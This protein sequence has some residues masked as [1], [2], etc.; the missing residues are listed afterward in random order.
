MRT[1]G[2][3]LGGKGDPG[4]PSGPWGAR[5]HLQPCR[6]QQR[7]C[8][9]S[10]GPWALSGGCGGGWCCNPRLHR[11]VGGGREPPHPGTKAH[12]HGTPGHCGVYPCL[13]VSICPGRM[14]PVP[15]GIAGGPGCG[16]EWDAG[17][18]APTR[19]VLPALPP[20]GP[21]GSAR[22]PQPWLPPRGRCPPGVTAPA[23]GPHQPAASAAPRPPPVTPTHSVHRRKHPAR[24][25]TDP[26]SGPGPPTGAAPA[27]WAPPGRAPPAHRAVRGGCRARRRPWRRGTDPAWCPG[28]PPRGR[29][30]GRAGAVSRGPPTGR[31]AGSGRAGARGA[32]RG[33]GGVGGCLC[34]Y[35][36]VCV[37][38]R[39]RV[40]AGERPWVGGCGCAPCAPGSGC[41]RPCM[42]V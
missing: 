30:A 11:G 39:G 25:Q 22:T 13:G 26:G 1:R 40:C 41:A 21:G 27:A 33:G 20:R 15:Q 38:A 12:P 16:G 7:R 4:C 8:R 2:A 5:A 28:P 31:G 23:P 18:R 34:A 6:G 19:G 37:C 17:V 42:H 24:R 32:G 35:V 29:A 9:R 36:C 10:W 14:S 3:R